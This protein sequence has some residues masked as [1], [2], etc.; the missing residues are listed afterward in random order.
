MKMP[1]NQSGF[2][3]IELMITLAVAIVFLAFGIPSFQILSHNNRVTSQTN[4]FSAF[5]QMARG[6][7]IKRGHSVRITSTAGAGSNEWGGGAQMVD[8]TTAEVIAVLD[9]LP[10]NLTLD[11]SSDVTTLT[12]ISKGYLSPVPGGTFNVCKDNNGEKGTSFTINAVGKINTTSI[13]CN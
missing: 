5:L 13:T 9:P 10:G 11:S 7:A 1:V 6:E 8:A 4:A 2:T 12:F 3:L